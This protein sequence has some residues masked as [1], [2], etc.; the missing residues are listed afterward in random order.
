M[1]WFPDYEY[2]LG[3]QSPRRQQL[4]KGLGLPFTVRVTDMPED[5]PEGLQMTEIPVYL[6]RRK[7]EHLMPHSGNGE[8]LITADTIVWLNGEV[9]GKP[10][11]E[12]H[13]REILRKLSGQTHQV[14]TGVCLR[15]DHKI[16]TFFS[17][18]DVEFKTLSPSEI[19]YYIVEYKPFD[20]AGAYGIQEWIG[21]A[22]I[23]SINGSYFNVVGLP[24]HQVYVE[25]LQ[26]DR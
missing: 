26:F 11:D 12:T 7:A 23:I 17:V 19:D 8:M 13:A 20:K 14:V 9:L 24:V 2:V 3:S 6:A 25:I 21:L 10:G 15:T 18:T 5:Y 16:R 1:N 22:G 4:L